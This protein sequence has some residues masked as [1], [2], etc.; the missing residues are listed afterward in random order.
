MSSDLWRIVRAIQDRRVERQSGER[1]ELVRRADDGTAERYACPTR[2]AVVLAAEA[3]GMAEL[4]SER[5]YQ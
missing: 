2:C 1:S 5:A 3:V 4:S